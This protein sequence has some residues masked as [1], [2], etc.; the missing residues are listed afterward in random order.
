M[1]DLNQNIAFSVYV[2]E[3]DLKNN[4]E[5]RF[6]CILYTEILL[7]LWNN[8]EIFGRTQKILRMLDPYGDD[9]LDDYDIKMMKKVCQT[10][11]QEDVLKHLTDDYMR[12]EVKN[13]D[14]TPEDVSEY[15]VK[16]ANEMIKGCDYALENNYQIQAMGD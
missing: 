6:I 10:I 2:N 13:K 5:E 4:M 9:L 14:V 3:E 7:L 8:C 16:F 1:L 11:L 12:F 15:L